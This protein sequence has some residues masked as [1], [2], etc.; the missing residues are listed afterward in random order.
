MTASNS[1][2]SNQDAGNAPG[3][4]PDVE[5]GIDLD[6]LDRRPLGQVGILDGVDEGPALKGD[7]RRSASMR[8]SGVVMRGSI[9]RCRLTDAAGVQ[10][11]VTVT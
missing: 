6:R 7:G 9:G 4:G 5:V 1:R 8:G 11:R 3:H 10:A 2:R